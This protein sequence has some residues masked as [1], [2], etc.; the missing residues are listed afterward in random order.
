LFAKR[1]LRCSF[2]SVGFNGHRERSRSRD[3]D[4][5]EMIALALQDPAHPVRHVLIG[6]A[7]PYLDDRSYG[8]VMKLARSISIAF[9]MLPFPPWLRLCPTSVI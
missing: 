8:L 5:R 1:R 3:G 6:G 4:I 9:P 2:C 7:T